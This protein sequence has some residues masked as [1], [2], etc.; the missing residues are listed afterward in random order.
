MSH[1]SASA[2]EKKRKTS[3]MKRRKPNEKKSKK[4]CMG[5]ESGKENLMLKKFN[6][7]KI[8]SKIF[9]M[10]NKLVK[11]KVKGEGGVEG[12]V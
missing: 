1:Q 2:S 11:V 4:A 9:E 5:K 10:E 3:C 7:S 6:K 8:K 12:E